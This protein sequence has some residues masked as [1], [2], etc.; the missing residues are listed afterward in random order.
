VIRHASGFI[1]L[2]LLPALARLGSAP[3]RF[4]NALGG[5]LGE[6]VVIGI[7]DFYHMGRPGSVYRRPKSPAHFGTRT[8]SSERIPPTAWLF[9]VVRILGMTFVVP[10]A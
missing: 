9:I 3:L 4:G 5:E 6:S 10:P 1:L 8:L 2:K 7:G